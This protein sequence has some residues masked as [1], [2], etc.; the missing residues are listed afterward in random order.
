[1]TCVFPTTQNET[2]PVGLELNTTVSEARLYALEAFAMFVRIS[3]IGD[4]QGETLEF[5]NRKACQ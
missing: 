4:K 3:N 2:P 5:A 1:M